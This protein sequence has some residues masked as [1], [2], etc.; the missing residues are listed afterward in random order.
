MADASRLTRRPSAHRRLAMLAPCW[1]MLAGCNAA[2]P[3]SERRNAGAP[4]TAGATSGGAGMAQAAGVGAGGR[5]AAG[6]GA[7]AAGGTAG[8]PGQAGAAA[9]SGGLSA[10]VGGG[11]AGGAAG[12]S[13]APSPACPAGAFCDSF[14]TGADALDPARWSV[15]SPSC[16]G[17]GRAEIDAAM[18]HTGSRSLRVTSS[19][20]YCNHVFASAVMALPDAGV[21]YGRLF[22]R[23]ERALAA[24]HVTFMALHDA[25]EGKELRMGGQS[26]ILMWNR[27]SDDATLPELSP[28]GIAL[29]VKPE[30]NRWLC[31]EFMIDGAQRKLATWV[32][33]AAVAGLQVEGE[34]TQ[35]VDGQW[36]SKASWMPQP[37]DAK[38]GWESYG[39]EAN[40]LWFDDV[41]LGSTRFG[42]ER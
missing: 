17:D 4:S 11:G 3:A 22:V 21:L 37:S 6:A 38:F 30:I 40:T 18:A 35:D 25:S 24:G 19:G 39:A 26:E 29:S 16:S 8:G 41:A 2:A 23:F 20:G 15:V 1:I 31:I 10:G 34:A 12:L 33:G 27:E 9:G 5:S 36:L 7:H 42:C 13:G 28:A 14:E 32:D